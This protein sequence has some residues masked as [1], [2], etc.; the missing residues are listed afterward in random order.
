MNRRIFLQGMAVALAA[1][2]GIAFAQY[3]RVAGAAVPSV[4]GAATKLEAAARPRCARCDQR[5]PDYP[6]RCA[7]ESEPHSGGL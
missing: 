5:D 7:M 2:G 6:D 1:G 3:R 4:A